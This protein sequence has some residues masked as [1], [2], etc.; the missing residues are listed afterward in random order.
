V[1]AP[2]I[3][4]DRMVRVGQSCGDVRRV[5]RS[6][7]RGGGSARAGPI[8]TTLILGAVVANINTSISNVA[9]P[10]IGRPWRPGPP[11]RR[12]PFS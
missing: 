2:G 3:T 8:L 10:S 1:T 5:H 11:G 9:L 12:C 7:G 4:A 6:T